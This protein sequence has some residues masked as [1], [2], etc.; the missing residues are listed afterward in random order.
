MLRERSKIYNEYIQYDSTHIKLW[1]IQTNDRGR[2]VVAQQEGGG[3]DGSPKG[4]KATL[5]GDENVYYPD[6]G[7]GFMGIYICQK[8]IKLCNLNIHSSLYFNYTP[9]KLGKNI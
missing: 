7:D 6:G 8:W 4:H 1:N 5:V 2:S 9:I 3:K